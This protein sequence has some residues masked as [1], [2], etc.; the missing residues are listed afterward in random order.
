MLYTY[1]YIYINMYV[2]IYIYIHYDPHWGIWKILAIRKAYK[3]Y[4]YVKNH[5]SKNHQYVYIYIYTNPYRGISV[6]IVHT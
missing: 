6:K 5:I 2:C 4:Y 1:I 3:P